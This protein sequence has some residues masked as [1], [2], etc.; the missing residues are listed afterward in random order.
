MPGICEESTFFI[1]A[2]RCVRRKK[3]HILQPLKN[4]TTVH[5]KYI[6]AAVINFVSMDTS[7]LPNPYQ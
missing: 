6:Y 3:S 7:I 4:Y 1:L 5:V 2:A